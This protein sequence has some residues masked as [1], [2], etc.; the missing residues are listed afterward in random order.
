LKEKNKNKVTALTVM[1]V[2]SVVVVI[3]GCLEEKNRFQLLEE[4]TLVN[5]NKEYGA[6]KFNLTLETNN[7]AKKI[8]WNLMSETTAVIP[9]KAYG[10]PIGKNAVLTVVAIPEGS[11][12]KITQVIEC[13]GHE[14]IRVIFGYQQFIDYEFYNKE[15]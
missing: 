10:F 14:G 6:V 12:K 7:G 8:S 4:I 15:I 13:D 2:V 5:N 1:A 11:D 3:P 9:L